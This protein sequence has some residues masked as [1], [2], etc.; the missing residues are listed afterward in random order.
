MEKESYTFLL[1]SR[2]R[3][4]SQFPDS[5][6]YTIAFNSPFHDVISLEL[7][8][9]HVPRSEYNIDIDNNTLRYTLDNDEQVVYELDVE[10]GDYSLLQLIDYMN[11]RLLGGLEIEPVAVPYN[12]TNRIRFNR[13]D[14][15]FSILKSSIC[16]T[17]GLECNATTSQFREVEQE[18]SFSTPA[19]PGINATTTDFQFTSDVD[20]IS[21][22]SI[23]YTIRSIQAPSENI[24]R[25]SKVV[26]VVLNS[27]DVEVGRATW[28]P[29]LTS[30]VTFA[31]KIRLDINETYTVKIESATIPASNIILASSPVSGVPAAV[32]VISSPIQSIQPSNLIDLTGRNS[33]VFIRCPEIESLIYRERFNE[34][35][36]H[37][38]MGYIRLTT[39][40]QN[41]STQT[42]YFIPYPAR[43]L[44]NPLSRFKQMSIRLE[45]TEGNLYNTRGLDHQLLFRVTYYKPSVPITVD[46]GRN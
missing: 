34:H 36:L 1:D 28:Y 44:S 45:T 42:N 14:G 19:V 22:N 4:L 40:G 13:P 6:A 16:K 23:T 38:G 37:T 7:L 12:L 46:L 32:L 31:D 35:L 10:P 18:A 8:N 5:N 25:D 39:V 21:L 24:A 29:M 41:E 30:T 26:V 2:T 27:S 43:T 3:D 11:R 20:S 15:E 33:T 9:C 17:L